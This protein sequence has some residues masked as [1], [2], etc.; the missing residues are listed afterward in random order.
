MILLEL[1]PWPDR[2]MKQPY[3]HQLDVT[4]QKVIMNRNHSIR[5][6]QMT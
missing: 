5:I 2:L 4:I 1:Y 3:N 6:K